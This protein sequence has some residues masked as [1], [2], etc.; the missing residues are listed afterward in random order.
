M[1]APVPR[2]VSRSGW[3]G[4]PPWASSGAGSGATVQR[5]ASLDDAC[6]PGGAVGSPRPYARVTELVQALQ[7]GY[8]ELDGVDAVAAAA[9]RRRR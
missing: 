2:S 9:S 7:R 8:L 6:A 1:A 4:P 5:S 3:G